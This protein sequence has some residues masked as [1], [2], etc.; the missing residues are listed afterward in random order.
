MTKPGLGAAGDSN[1][2]SSTSS[3]LVYGCIVSMTVILC[4]SSVL[5]LTVL[6]KGVALSKQNPDMFGMFRRDAIGR[7]SP[8]HQ[9]R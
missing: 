5:W 8:K 7:R 9:S 4:V 1:R 2:T 3:N 6:R